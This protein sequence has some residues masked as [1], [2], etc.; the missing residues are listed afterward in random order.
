M[1]II[2][3]GRDGG[4][5]IAWHIERKKQIRRIMRETVGEIDIIT[6]SLPSLLSAFAHIVFA[7][8]IS[9]SLFLASKAPS[10]TSRKKGAC[11]F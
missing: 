1:T 4:S 2:V 3:M 5:E 10:E 9:A 11:N 6:A 8:A 7:L